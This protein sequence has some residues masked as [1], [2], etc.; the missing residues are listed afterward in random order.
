MVHRIR[1]P[2]PSSPFKIVVHNRF[3]EG[4]ILYNICVYAAMVT[5]YHA[6]DFDAHFQWADERPSTTPRI[7]YYAFMSHANVMAGECTPTTTLG[8]GLLSMHILLSWG[9]MMLLLAPWS[10]V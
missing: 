7:M 1:I 10:A 4:I 6:I 8:R 2:K 9:L 5:L 3:L